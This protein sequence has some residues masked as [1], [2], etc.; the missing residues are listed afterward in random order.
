VTQRRSREAREEVSAGGVVVRVVDGAPHVLLIRDPYRNWGLPKGHVEGGEEPP[1]A[2][3]REV[4]EE[5]GLDALVLGPV[6]GTIDWHFRIRGTLVH[7]YCHFFLMVSPDGDT[8]PQHAEGITECRWLPLE[9][10]MRS[11]TYDNAREMIRIA[12][13]ILD[14]SG[15]DGLN[16]T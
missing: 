10:A 13:R 4:Q 2:A 8:K 7:K 12:V 5:T 3:L 1:E 9:E 14:E 6:L 11:V 15:V 16:P